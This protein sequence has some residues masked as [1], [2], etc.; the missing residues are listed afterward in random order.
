M[1]NKYLLIPYG[2]V[3]ALLSLF[4][5]ITTYY[6]YEINFQK[7]VGSFIV[8]CYEESCYASPV[9][10]FY[11][12]GIIVGLV[13]GITLIFFYYILNK[14]GIVDYLIIYFKNMKNKGWKFI[15]MIVL[16]IFG[17][18]FYI[19]L[20]TINVIFQIDINEGNIYFIFIISLNLSQSTK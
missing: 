9:R 6:I 10:N 16:S 18:A 20:H 3:I 5:S 2:I 7:I 15:F 17:Y 14:I 19:L 13:L 12:L 11:L 4:V 8:F 1:K